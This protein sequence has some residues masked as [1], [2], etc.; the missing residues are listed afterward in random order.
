MRGESRVALGD[1]TIEER[2]GE[3]C[4]NCEEDFG[5]L[6]VPEYCVAREIAIGSQRR[7]VVFA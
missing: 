3:G 2:D 6:D 1:Y 5:C 4:D 7:S